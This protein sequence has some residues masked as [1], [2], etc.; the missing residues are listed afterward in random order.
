MVVRIREVEEALG[1]AAPRAVSTGEMMNRVNLAKSL[2]AA[3]RPRA[4][5]HHRPRRRRHQEPRPRPAAQ[6]PRPAGRPHRQPRAATPAT[7]STPPTCR[8]PCR[9]AATTSSVGRGACRCATTT[10]R[11]SPPTAPP[12]SSS[13]TSPTRTSRSTPRPCCPTR[14]PMGYACHAPDLFA[15]DFILNLASE[16]DAH[17]ER[18]IAELQ[19]VIDLTRS[20]R[21]FFTTDVDPVVISSVGGFTKR[22]A[23]AARRAARHVRAGRRR[24]R[25]GRRLGRAAV[26]ARRCRRSPGT[27]VASCTATCSSAPPTPPS[28]PSATAAASAST[29]RTPSS[30][31][32][33]SGQPF[34]EAV[35]LLAPHSR[36]PAPRRLRRRRRRG[37]PGRR[38]RDRLAGARPPAR[39]CSRP[40]VGLHPRDLAGPRQQRRGLLA[41]A[42]AAGAVVL[43]G[44]DAP[45]TAL[46]VVPVGD[47]GRGRRGTSSTSSR[48]GVPGHRLVVLLP[49]RPARRAAAGGWAPRW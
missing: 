3:P 6:R 30:P 47:A 49:A 15:G 22:R 12:T 46:W 9:R 33:S 26:A 24:P 34:S 31:R 40:G 25:P 18:S 8:M 5:R 19:R 21:P 1:S 42:G 41:G 7:S 32:P 16:D 13:S 4:R 11:P 20:L 37:R 38:R 35:E 2:V 48:S 45:P 43:T 27:W 14:L 10:S 36:P 44:P 28:S 23:R 29:C 39:R 17:W